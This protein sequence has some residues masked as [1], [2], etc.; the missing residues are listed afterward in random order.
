MIW[1]YNY[2]AADRR[3]IC[4]SRFLGLPLN[5]MVSSQ[6][7]FVSLILYSKL[8]PSVITALM[9]S[10]FASHLLFWL[11]GWLE[12]KSLILSSLKSPVTYRRIRS[13]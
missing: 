10:F 3:L 9:Q 13:M 1:S 6:I 11:W 4:T 7:P 12:K 5:E 2:R 8:S